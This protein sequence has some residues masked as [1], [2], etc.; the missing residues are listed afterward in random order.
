[1]AKLGRFHQQGFTRWVATWEPKIVITRVPGGTPGPEFYLQRL[2]HTQ[3]TP[4]L[5][6][7]KVLSTF[8]GVIK[9]ENPINMDP[10]VL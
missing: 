6:K 5:I 7:L 8:G 1:M 3:R 10:I 2:F 4:I 9:V